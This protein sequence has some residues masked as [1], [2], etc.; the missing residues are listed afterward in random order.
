MIVKKSSLI[1]LFLILFCM[2]AYAGAWVEAK[3]EGLNI[4]S[5]SQYENTEYWNTN[6]NLASSPKYQKYEISDYLDYG[7]TNNF[8]VGFLLSGL[9]SDIAG[10]E[11]QTGINDQEI[12]GHYQFW[13]DDYS[14]LSTQIFIDY[15]GNAANFSSFN[16]EQSSGLNTGEAL[17]YGT[18]GVLKEDYG[19]F[20][21]GLIGTVQRYKNGDQAELNL[22]AGLKFDKDK[23]WLMI[24]NYNTFSLINLS[25]P[26][27]N[28]Y[29]LSKISP[30]L[31]YWL[32]PIISIQVGVMQDFYGVNTG[33]G[34][35]I[36]ASV[37]TKF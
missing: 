15:L 4:F 30:S 25:H 24:Q 7:L 17:L 14:V 22:E 33:K 34:R 11:T 6:Q 2:R 29:N 27:G 37:W 28:N 9:Q 10:T 12:F 23:V 21:D 20:V 32:N 31:V 36:F 35:A 8:T 19:W 1:I 16:D 5:F 26:S 18:G 13:H 3:G